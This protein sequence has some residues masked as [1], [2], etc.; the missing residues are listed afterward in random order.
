MVYSFILIIGCTPFI[1]Q[2]IEVDINVIILLMRVI[3][4]KLLNFSSL[5]I[6]WYFSQSQFFRE[7]VYILLHILLHI[8]LG[9]NKWISWG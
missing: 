9:E 1:H 6:L 8:L 7:N 4:S 2:N 3:L 5:L